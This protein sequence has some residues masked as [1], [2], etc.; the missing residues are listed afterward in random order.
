MARAR[1]VI[2]EI[3]A[4]L[5][6]AHRAGIVHGDV[7]PGNIFLTST[8]TARL[9]DFG[10]ARS[11]DA[12]SD[13]LTG[14]TPAYASCEV[15]AGEAAT[16]QDD[17]FSLGCVAYRM[18]AGRRAFGRLSAPEAERAAKQP[19]RIVHLTDG[20]WSALSYAL[21][22]RR[23][24]RPASVEDFLREF[25]A[26]ANAAN[27]PHPVHALPPVI[28]RIAPRQRLVA[29]A[30]ALVACG[31]VLAMLLRPPA[32]APLQAAAPLPVP[33]AAIA[34][35]RPAATDAT[36][37]GSRPSGAI[38]QAD[39]ELSSKAAEPRRPAPAAAGAANPSP[40]KQVAARAA[41][42]GA[43]S[44]ALRGPTRPAAKNTPKEAAPRATRSNANA[45]APAGAP[46]GESV[47]KLMS[48][49]FRPAASGQAALLPP[50]TETPDGN[51]AG[52]QAGPAFV[53]LSNLRFTKFVEPAVPDAIGRSNRSGWVLVS[54]HIDPKGRT[55]NVS[56]I[57]SSPKGRY[58]LQA[59]AA[60][61]RWRFEPVME[62]G[63]PVERQTTVR[64]RFETK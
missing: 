43:T 55:D 42:T 12:S 11:L 30:A 22:F 33:A 17:V 53:A 10:A 14:K 64:I 51:A 49:D 8:G 13:T 7:K 56:V 3:G 60:I 45:A 24:E 19:A 21:S 32:D 2:E 15:L 16:R 1:Q 44:A 47:T 40:R 57:E 31:V 38:A 9:L 6:H 54:F 34:P 5:A 27:P 20:Q 50:A 18:L 59:L 23:A 52:A 36:E 26:D 39:A 35:D 58:D 28:V 37:T 61:R 41:P 62:A 4:A 25:A 46:Q 48:P 63:R 29:S